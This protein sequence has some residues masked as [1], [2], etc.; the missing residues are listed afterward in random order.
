MLDDEACVHVA[1]LEG[2]GLEDELVVGGGGGH[3]GNHGLVEGTQH[4]GDSRVPIRAPHNQLAQQRVVVGW[5]Q[6]LGVHVAVHAHMGA[7]GGKVGGHAAGTGA[8]VLEW[9]LGVDTALNGV[10]LELDILLCELELLALCHLDLL[11]DQIHAG[12]HLSHGVLHLDTGVHLHEV[13]AL[14]L[15]Q[16]LNGAHTHIADSLGGVD[17]SITHGLAHLRCQGGA[18]RLLQE[19][20]VAP[21]DRAV[22]LTQVHHVA[23]L[24]SQD[25]ELNVAGGLHVALNVD[26]AVAEGRLRLLLGLLEE[27]QQVLLLGAQAHAAAAT[28]GSRLD[29]D[30]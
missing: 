19:L 10:T 9:I 12:D 23:V 21:L 6:V 26:R 17:G 8:E 27:G 18:G 13:E 29:H 11:L 22:A 25:L 15:P 4:A 5:H 24:V 30:R 7:T 16:E 1:V 28:T 2:L 20:L 14:L 3:T